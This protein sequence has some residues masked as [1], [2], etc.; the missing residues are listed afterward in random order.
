MRGGL[1][2]LGA[3]AVVSP[4][5]V[6]VP[7][8][9]IDDRKLEVAG[10][11]AKGEEYRGASCSVHRGEMVEQAGARAD[12]RP[13]LDRVREVDDLH[14]AEAQREEI[15]QRA[16]ERDGERGARP[17]PGPRG[18]RA[19]HPRVESRELAALAKR[20]GDAANAV[21]P[22]SVPPL[23]SDLVGDLARRDGG[24][25]RDLNEAVPA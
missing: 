6:R 17:E 7:R 1:L 8:S 20:G 12:E 15:R 24:V 9:G 2:G 16:N 25:A 4:G 13:V 19:G 11:V 21:A 23:V 22:G 10:P 5:R 3:P 18:Q 14:V